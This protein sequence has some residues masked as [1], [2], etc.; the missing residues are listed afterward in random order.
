M[1][2]RVRPFFAWFKQLMGC[3][4]SGAN[5][6]LA[7]PRL[8]PRFRISIKDYAT[9][10]TLKIELTDQLWPGRYWIRQD[11]KEPS[12]QIEGSLSTVF[13]K[14]R[15]WTVSQATRRRDSY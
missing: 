4:K 8:K 3:G 6:V 9:G 13:A 12:R 5:F 1:A 2:E 14:L 11:G 7:M 15:R 10:R